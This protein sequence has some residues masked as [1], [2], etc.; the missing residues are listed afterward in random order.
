MGPTGADGPMGLTGPTGPTGP[1]GKQGQGSLMVEFELDE[2]TGTS[3]ADTSG[4]ENTA[5][6]PI[7]GLAPG[8]TGHT[9]R[10]INFSGGVLTVPAPNTIP[11]SAQIWVEAWI[12]PQAPLNTLRTIV[13][14][15]GVY[16][17][18][19]TNTDLLFEVQGAASMTTCTATSS[20]VNLTAG[21]WYHVSAWYN[22]L[23]VQL[24]VDGTV[25]NTVSCSAG[26]L[27]KTAPNALHIGGKWDGTAVTEPYAGTID[28]L[29]VRSTAPL[30]VKVE[31]PAG[32]VMFFDL[33]S[34]PPGWSELTQARG[35]YLVG[36]P[37]AGTPGA[38]VG[39]AL[40]DQENRAV[41]EHGHGIAQTPHGHGVSDPG[42]RHARLAGSSN[43][44]GQPNA[45]WTSG[46][47]DLGTS[48]TQ[49]S[50][51]GISINGANANITVNNSG[52]VPGTNAPYVQL[53]TC[54]KN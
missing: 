49:F 31:N 14:K 46:N 53:L 25:R 27:V 38:A 40:S 39:T 43:A 3:F 42:H 24:A 19:Q 50:T 32:S 18:K 11:D 10:A 17:L 22:G 51:T 6:A 2:P 48:F 52:S 44:S 54:R 37:A 9:L 26:P 23:T 36:L 29:R 12:Q 8:S 1:T 34:C 15:D 33:P 41:G 30:A 16:A 20:G 13:I 21:N 7:G 47:N 4:L 35:R 5:T 28:E 45:Y